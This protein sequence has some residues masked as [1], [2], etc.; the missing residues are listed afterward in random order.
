MGEECCR[1][2]REISIDALASGT[3]SKEEGC[4]VAAEAQPSVSSKIFGMIDE[5]RRHEMYAEISR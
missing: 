5:A 2:R 4:G 1:N 3:I